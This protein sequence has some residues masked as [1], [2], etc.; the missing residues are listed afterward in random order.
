MVD[1][2]EL[3]FHLAGINNQNFLMRD[4]ETGSYWQQISGRAIAGPYRG[5]Q[6]DLIHSDELTFA[7]WRGENPAGT[8]LRPVG[9]FASQYEDKNWEADMRRVRTVVD[10]KNTPFGPRELMLGV[11]DNGSA[12]A[13]VFDRVLKQKLIQDRIGA[14]PVIVVAGPDGKSVRVFEARIAGVSDVP[15]FYRNTDAPAPNAGGPIL[16]DSLTG[17]GWNFQGCA[18]SGSAA[19]QCLRPMTAIKDYWFDWRLYHPHTTVNLK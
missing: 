17:G 6:L 11:E 8:V 18:V 9:K 4:E 5:R 7:L 12:R 14:T 13:Y 15:E 2:R 3:T 16:M 1:G 19:G 10:T